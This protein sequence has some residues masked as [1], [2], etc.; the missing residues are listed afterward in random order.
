[1]S[2]AVHDLDLVDAAAPGLGNA[3]VI[4]VFGTLHP[5]PAALAA[6]HYRAGRAPLVVLTGGPNRASGQ[7]EADLHAELL[8]S[9]GVPA[10]AILLERKSVNTWENVELASTLLR[11]RGEHV[12]SVITVVKWYHRR[13]LLILASRMPEVERVFAVD[14][15]PRDPAT[16][17][18]VTR[19]GWRAGAASVARETTYMR[20]LLAKGFD[21]L[22]RDG[23]GW[24]RTTA[25]NIN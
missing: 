11:Q 18:C 4:L 2:S 10:D 5:T 16:G 14:Y 21:P 25:A 20:D 23:Q 15:E 1:M 3:D 8:R 13:A 22:Q 9:V 24:V 19:T 6:E 12:R 17:H 7:V